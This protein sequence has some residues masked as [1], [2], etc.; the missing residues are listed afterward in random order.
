MQCKQRDMSHEE[1]QRFIEHELG[2]KQYM[3]PRKKALHDQQPLP[4]TRQYHLPK[5]WR[6]RQVELH[7]QLNGQVIPSLQSWRAVAH[8]SEVP[9]V[10]EL[11]AFAKR[12]KCL[13][14]PAAVMSPESNTVPVFT[15]ARAS[16]ASTPEA[17]KQVA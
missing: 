12:V 10:E 3:R 9:R 1:A 6:N 14:R 8:A 7:Q 2:Y 5:T 16:F 17:Q 13:V 4:K 15:D 11:L